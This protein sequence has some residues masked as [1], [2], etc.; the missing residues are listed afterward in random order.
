[1]PL[2]DEILAEA[3]RARDRLIG[4]QHEVDGARSDYHHA[5][6]RLCATGGSLR[7]I[8][9]ALGISHQRVHQIV[10]EEARPVWRRRGRTF[11]PRGGF[12]Q[13]TGRSRAVMVAAQEEARVL[14]HDYLGTEH[15]LLALLAV[16]DGGAAKALHA[17]G[18]ELE[19]ARGAVREL[20]GEGAG[21][22]PGRLAFTKQAKR[23]LE[24]AL[25]ESLRL[26]HTHIGTEHVLLALSG[27]KCIAAE[28]L[29]QLGADE[30]RIRH[31]VERQL[32]A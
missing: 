20:V 16:E 1:M 6:R 30:E 21:T 5:I 24:L 2:D 29:A 11:G 23:T 32:A 13:F 18:V 15:I 31:E 28:V 4:A 3:K 7:E 10:D 27:Q 8:A 25:R 12:R 19:A 17:L 22:P 26:G 14:R 9:E